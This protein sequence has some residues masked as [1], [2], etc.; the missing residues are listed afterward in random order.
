MLNTLRFVRGAIAKRELIPVLSHFHVYDGRIQGSNGKIHIDAPCED[1]KG[2]NFTVP[3]ERF[4]KAV[5]ACDGEPKLKVT[6][7]QKLSI[8]KGSFRALLPL[9]EHDAFPITKSE[10]K[11]VKYKGGLLQ[12]FKTVYNFIGEDASRPWAC[13]CL[14]RDGYVWAT[15]N[16]VLIRTPFD[17]ELT[18]LNVPSFAV[19][20]LL[21]IG[22][23]FSTIKVTK[24]TIEFHYKNG[25]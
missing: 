23:E 16:A 14:I 24:N 19:D 17:G 25:A 21:R 20:E 2:F 7:K 8:S 4:L 10:G 1:L 3:A 15:N 13:G 22:E 11:R 5:D 6:A 18:E 12:C 9:G